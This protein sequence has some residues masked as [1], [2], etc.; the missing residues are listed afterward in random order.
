MVL[1]LIVLHFL[2]A[3]QVLGKLTLDSAVVW[4]GVGS[5]N[6]VLDLAYGGEVRHAGGT[7]HVAGGGR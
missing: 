1:R 6:L 4:Y 2:I 5:D 7:R 3:D